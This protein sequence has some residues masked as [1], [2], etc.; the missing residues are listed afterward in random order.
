MVPELAMTDLNELAILYSSLEM[1]K[2]IGTGGFG[3]VYT[4]RMKPSN[5]IVAVKKLLLN[6]DED[7]DPTQNQVMGLMFLEKKPVY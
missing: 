3:E 2:V 1:I 4:A 7:F 6:V 5:Q